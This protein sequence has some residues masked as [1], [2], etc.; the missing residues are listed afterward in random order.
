MGTIEVIV[1]SKQKL[2]YKKKSFLFAFNIR[3]GKWKL[4]A[5]NFLKM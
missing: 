3:H 1:I 2:K 5:I 4:E